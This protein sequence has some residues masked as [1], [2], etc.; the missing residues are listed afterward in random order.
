MKGKA[1]GGSQ[2]ARR[3]EEQVA[4]TFYKHQVLTHSHSFILA[5]IHCLHTFVRI[6]VR[7]WIIW[8]AA[9][10]EWMENGGRLS[11]WLTCC[12]LL[13]DGGYP[14]FTSYITQ[15]WLRFSFS[16]SSCKGPFHFVIL[17]ATSISCS[18][19]QRK[20]PRDRVAGE[21]IYFL[22]GKRWRVDVTVFFKIWFVR[23]FLRLSSSPFASA[24]A[25]A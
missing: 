6:V 11:G 25:A 21:C 7:R 17:M 4:L 23:D 10:K 5:F 24:P 22:H 20:P 13:V 2:G 1:E 3:D 14:Q 15:N 18:P 16:S 12:L 8:G 19:P 9:H